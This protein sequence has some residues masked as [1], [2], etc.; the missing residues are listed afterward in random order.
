VELLHR[1]TQVCLIEAVL[2]VPAKWTVEASLL[3]NGME[4]AKTEQ[5]LTEFLLLSSSIEPLFIV[6]RI[7]Q[8]RIL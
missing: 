6:N 1:D 4:E 5:H 7:D 2:D 8:E 3:D